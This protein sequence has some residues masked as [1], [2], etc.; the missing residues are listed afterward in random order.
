MSEFGLERRIG[1]GSYSLDSLFVRLPFA[2]THTVFAYYICDR[3]PEFD[4][5]DSSSREKGYGIFKCLNR[6]EGR[7]NYDR[8]GRVIKTWDEFQLADSSGY[9]A[10]IHCYIPDDTK[11]G[12]DVANWGYICVPKMRTGYLDFFENDLTKHDEGNIELLKIKN[13]SQGRIIEKLL[14]HFLEF[15]EK[16]KEDDF[17]K[18][19]ENLALFFASQITAPEGKVHYTLVGREMNIGYEISFPIPYPDNDF[20]SYLV[21]EFVQRAFSK[22]DSHKT[23]KRLSSGFKIN[24][25]DL[26]D[27][28]HELYQM[29]NHLI[30]E[31]Q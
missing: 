14:E 9:F 19:E 2:V 27:I 20:K 23:P 13:Y 30:C 28:G 24:K 22:M 16:N 7:T 18:A 3:F 11:E 4:L 8:G 6:V 10:Y 1:E 31:N 21:H 17:L 15:V 26:R 12:L 5:T 25:D 29:H